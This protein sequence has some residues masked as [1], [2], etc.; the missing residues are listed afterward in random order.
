MKLPFY[1]TFRRAREIGLDRTISALV[2]VSLQ[3]FLAKARYFPEYAITDIN[4]S[5]MWVLP[6]SGGIHSDLF[7]YGRREPICTQYLMQSDLIGRGDCVLDIGANIGYYILLESKLVGS[8]GK[9]YA[10]EPVLNNFNLLTKNVKLNNLANVSTHQLAIG[11]RNCEAKIYVSNQA[12]LC[13]ME[14]YEDTDIVDTQEVEVKTVDTFLK[15]KETPKLIRMDVE[16]YEY[17]VLKGMS[18]TLKKD[19]ALLI[20]VHPQFLRG[21]I[22]DFLNILEKN[23]IG[24]AHV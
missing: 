4:G 14:K 11:D 22:D 18:Q 6:R 7:L 20:E 5:K 21:K 3:S 16:G 1:R 24:R 23:K 12:N 2:A 8:Q 19:I 10:V 15:N 13:R 9:I 17:E